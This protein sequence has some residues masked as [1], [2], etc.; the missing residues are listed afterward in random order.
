MRRL[1]C[2]KMIKRFQ[3]NE[4]FPW[5][6]FG[7]DNWNESG[8]INNYLFSKMACHVLAVSISFSCTN[9]IIFLVKSWT[10]YC[11]VEYDFLVNWMSHFKLRGARCTFFLLANSESIEGSTLFDQVPQLG[12]LSL[13]HISAQVN[14]LLREN[15]K[16]IPKFVSGRKL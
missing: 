10:V 16:S 4:R 14:R 2:G 13:S 7:T 6:Y 11:P 12:H 15:R 8:I 3:K 5:V 9:S 1:N